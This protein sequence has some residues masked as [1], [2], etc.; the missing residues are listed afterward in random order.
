VGTS[1]VV[2]LSIGGHPGLSA[3]PLGTFFLGASLV[4]LRV[5]PWHFQQ[6]GRKVGFLVGVA[7]GLLGTCLGIVAVLYHSPPLLIVATA[8]FGAAMGIG[9]YLRFAAIEVVPSHWADK[10][11]TLVVSGGC[12]AAFA[13]PESAQ[14]T[15]GIFGEEYEYLGVFVM[16]G[17]FNIANGVFTAMVR[18]PAADRK[19]NPSENDSQSTTIH[20]S[21]DK[22]ERWDRVKSILKSR[23]FM[24][25]ML[26]SAGS[27]IIMVLPMSIL[28]VAMADAGFTSR[29]SLLTI[30]LHFLC[31]Y[32]PGFFSGQ[33]IARYGPRLVSVA[34]VSISLISFACLQ[35][36]GSA[37]STSNAEGTELLL[38]ILGMALIG[39]GWNFSFSAGTVGSTRSYTSRKDCKSAIQAANDGVTFL[40]TGAVICSASYIYQAGGKGLAGWRVVNWVDLGFMVVFSILLGVDLWV[41]RR[42]SSGATT[43]VDSWASPSIQ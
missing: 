17:I 15:R 39:I 12:I 41:E 4:S 32:G 26:I 14:G 9:F 22:E 23:N 31:M 34:G 7:I 28:R 24:V 20:D 2:L 42:H 43:S 3:L 6:W 25:P 36:A 38:W 16:T 29:Q 8:A 5:T 27:W 10:A 21:F 1:N 13:G 33:W 35:L 19:T 18:F 37:N 40:L 30:E 11:V